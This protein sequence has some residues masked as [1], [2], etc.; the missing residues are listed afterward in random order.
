MGGK[1]KAERMIREWKGE[2][3][4]AVRGEREKKWMWEGK[5]K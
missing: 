5:W 2:G 4:R 1:W 3:Q